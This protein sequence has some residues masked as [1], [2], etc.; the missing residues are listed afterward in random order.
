MDK[1]YVK[2][3][4]TLDGYSIFLVDGPWIRA[5]KDIE[6]TNADQH[7]HKKYIPKKEVWIDSASDKP[8]IDFWAKSSVRE[9][10]MMAKGASWSKAETV[11]DSEEKK[12]R[13]TDPEKDKKF[14]E[15]SL[16]K[17][18]KLEVFLVDGR[19]VRDGPDIDFTEGGHNR[20]Y[21]W[22]KGNEIWLDDE[23]KK[24]ELP[25]IFL[26]E[27]FEWNKMGTGMKYENAHHLASA[28]ELKA[29]KKPSLY[30]AL[31]TPQLKKAG[32]SPKE[33]KDFSLIHGVTNG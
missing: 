3:Y 16:G 6:F 5:N 4:G 12:A 21:K 29:R 26:H 23:V 18:G 32:A 15:K 17:I 27:L 2:R 25:F 19:A 30:T 10:K 7:F 14:K 33:I 8:E 1:P 28:I 24:K 13:K 9:A 31:I 22:I 11:A 20:G